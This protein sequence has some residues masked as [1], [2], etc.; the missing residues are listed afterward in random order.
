M[1]LKANLKQYA[2]AM[3][4]GLQSILSKQKIKP[5]SKVNANIFQNDLGKVYFLIIWKSKDLIIVCWAYP[6]YYRLVISGTDIPKCA[7][8]QSIQPST[9]FAVNHCFIPQLGEQELHKLCIIGHTRFMLRIDNNQ[10]HSHVLPFQ[11]KI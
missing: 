8:S 7:Q 4:A 1:L 3:K 2:R 5:K 11:I 9:A 6:P 10:L